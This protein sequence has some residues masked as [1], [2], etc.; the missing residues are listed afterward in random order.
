MLL[1]FDKP[2]KLQVDASNVGAGAVLLQEG[3]SGV[4]QSVSFLKCM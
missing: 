1:Q 4:D 3:S 2:F